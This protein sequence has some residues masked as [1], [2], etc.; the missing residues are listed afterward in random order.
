MAV[1]FFIFS[2]C[3]SSVEVRMKADTLFVGKSFFVG[4]VLL[5]IVLGGI[6]WKCGTDWEPYYRFF[7]NYTTWNQYNNGTFEILYSLLN[8]LVKKISSSYTA[9]LFVL[10]ALV[11]TLKY[12]TI[13][14]IALYPALSYYLFFCANIGDIFPVR[15]GLAISIALL[16]IYFIHRKNRQVFFIITLVAVGVHNSMLIWFL[17]Y[18]VYNRYIRKNTF[19][20]L[21]LLALI[22]GV[23]GK[24]L[25]VPIIE[26]VLVRSGVSGPVASRLIGYGLGNYSDGSFSVLQAFLSVIKRMV[27]IPFFLILRRKLIKTNYEYM[28]GLINLY[29]IGN[30]IY[31]LFI[32]DEAFSPL[33]RMTTP[34]LFIETIVMPS[35]LLIFRK[36]YS[37]YLFLILL[38][39]YGLIKLNTALRGYP[40]AYMPYRTIFDH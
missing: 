26:G 6:R 36:Q 29:I 14:K 5:T 30:I 20:F 28:N 3:Y 2:I 22:C 10:S 39:L 35:L 32:F 31:M 38:M 21:F 16:S 25:Y 24:R 1:T 34:F 11:I 17:A 40:D 23:L 19:I 7:N 27:F 13:K 33:K 37:K 18:P 12:D 15:Q 4:F 8:F 9:F